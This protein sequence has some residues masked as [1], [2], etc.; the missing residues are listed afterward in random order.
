M[1]VTVV[2]TPRRPGTSHAW[3]CPPHALL[4]HKPSTQFPFAHC[5]DAVQ[6]PP[7]TI[8]ATQAPELQ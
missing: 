2:Q 6:A 1:P 5:S 4:Q 7:S 8:F 3:H